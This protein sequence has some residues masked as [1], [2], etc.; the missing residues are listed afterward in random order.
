MAKPKVFDWIES[1]SSKKTV[2]QS[3][4]SAHFCENPWA[5]E[6]ISS[7]ILFWWWISIQPLAKRE[8]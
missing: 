4:A 8:R 6:R 1:L 2:L 7:H 3:G 5:G